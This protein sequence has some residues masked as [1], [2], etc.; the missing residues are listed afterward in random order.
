MR[1]RAAVKEEKKERMEGQVAKKANAYLM[2]TLQK[3]L[4]QSGGGEGSY[5]IILSRKTHAHF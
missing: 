3:D 2:H 1:L 4:W 5:S